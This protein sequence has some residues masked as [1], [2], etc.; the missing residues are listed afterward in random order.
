MNGGMKASPEAQDAL[1]ELARLISDPT[2]RKG[3]D[4]R[5]ALGDASRHLPDELLDAMGDMSEH[6]LGIIA[7][8][9]E[10]LVAAGFYQELPSGGRV[11][12]F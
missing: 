6:E 12:F 2:K 3:L 7:D 11:C 4:P 10:N 5:S 9:C 1:G 8:H